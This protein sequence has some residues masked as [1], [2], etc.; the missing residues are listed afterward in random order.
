MKT[1]TDKDKK[2]SV[3]AT[4]AWKQ[5]RL[6]VFAKYKGTDPITNKALR[7]GWNCHH[8]DMSVE[9]YD[10]LSIERFVPLNKATH[11]LVHTLYR[12]YRRDPDVLERLRA[13]LDAMAKYEQL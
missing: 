4:Q 12:Y 7:P 3:R 6:V 9:N 11:E 10:D 1:T 2:T 5:H 8:L 13:V